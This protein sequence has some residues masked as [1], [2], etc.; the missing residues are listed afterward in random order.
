MS[1]AHSVAKSVIGKVSLQREVDEVSEV[2]ERLRVLA[3][4]RLQCC[5][6]RD[7]HTEV[8]SG[9]VVEIGRALAVGVVRFDEDRSAASRPDDGRVTVRT[10]DCNTYDRLVSVVKHVEEVASIALVLR[11]EFSH[12]MYVLRDMQQMG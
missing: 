5:D 1:A 3:D 12:G 11:S 6:E 4:E 10:V 7:E 9:S 8:D 2:S